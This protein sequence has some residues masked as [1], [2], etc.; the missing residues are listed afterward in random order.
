[1][2]ALTII[3]TFLSLTTY[4]QLPEVRSWYYDSL[5]SKISIKERYEL[6]QNNQKHGRYLFYY[7]N[8]NGKLQSEGNYVHSQKEGTWKETIYI[9]YPSASIFYTRHIEMKNDTPHGNYKE[10]SMSGDTVLIG[11]YKNGKM[12]GYWEYRIIELEGTHFIISGQYRNGKRIGKWTNLQY[13]SDHSDN[14]GIDSG[15]INLEKTE[16]YSV[17]ENKGYITYFSK[18]GKFKKTI[19]IN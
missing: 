10:V 3:L 5:G 7:P 8:P 9:F 11:E 12:H 15:I 16:P 13:Y 19:K 2:K 6:D 14:I 17:V 4:A 1:M 18:K